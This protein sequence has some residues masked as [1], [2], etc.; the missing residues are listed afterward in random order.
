MILRK[1]AGKDLSM[2]NKENIKLE[3]LIIFLINAL[4]LIVFLQIDFIETLYQYAVLYEVNELLGL[5]V[6]LTISLGVFSYRRW[7]HARK[8]LREV[9]HLSNHDHLT[10]LF[11]RRYFDEKLSAEAERIRR[12]G[13]T[14]SIILLDIDDFKGINDAYGH[15]VGD[16]CLVQISRLLYSNTRITD[17]VS[18]RGGEAFIILC[19]G[20]DLEGVEKLAEKLLAVVR[21]SQFGSIPQVTISAG[22]TTFGDQDDEETVVSRVDGLL[23]DAKAAGKDRFVAAA[24]T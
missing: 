16:E 21:S 19:P 23:N 2:P 5:G 24:G 13:K 11:N 17:T 1:P 4:F 6:T 14:F 8:L 9:Q 12:G 22:I 18:R 20:V 3:I 15:K 10:G 7:Q